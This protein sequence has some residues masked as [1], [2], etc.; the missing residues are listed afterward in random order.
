M[1]I[2]ARQCPN[3][4]ELESLVVRLNTGIALTEELE[5]EMCL[6]KGARRGRA[7]LTLIFDDDDGGDAA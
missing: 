2:R 5:E 6:L 1:L 4:S 7:N 3:L